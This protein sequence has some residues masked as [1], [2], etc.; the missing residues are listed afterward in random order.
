MKTVS[1]RAKK[2]IANVKEATGVEI[3]AVSVE[4]L[5]VHM[6]SHTNALVIPSIDKL[7]IDIMKMAESSNDSDWDNYESSP[8]NQDDESS[9][10]NL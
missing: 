3:N 10:L 7:Q 1:E 2:I 4:K 5:I 6:D 9:S 8:W